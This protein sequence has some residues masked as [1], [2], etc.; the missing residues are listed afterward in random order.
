MCL[1]FAAVAA[2][3]RYGAL[4]LRLNGNRFV[5]QVL[6]C[7]LIAEHM[8]A[9]ATVAK[10]LQLQVRGARRMRVVRLPH[11]NPAEHKAVKLW[12]GYHM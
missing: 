4:E 5:R 7:G 6:D 3:L 9:A 1:I 2:R 12:S 10:R 8:V 11:F